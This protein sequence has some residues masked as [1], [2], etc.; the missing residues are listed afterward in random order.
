MSLS[1]S[2]TAAGKR[3]R[4]NA[5][6]HFISRALSKRT[7]IK[8]HFT[9][10][11]LS[12]RTFIKGHFISL[13]FYQPGILSAW[14]FI[15][16]AFYQPSILS[17]WH[18]ISLAFGKMTSLNGIYQHGIWSNKLH[19]IAFISMASS[20]DYSLNGTSPNDISTSVI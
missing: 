12:N 17:A 7:F 20:N 1:F 5:T 19:L 3:V 16:L 13:V 11:A 18:F 15:S 14:H 4:V 8:W 10:L 2:L 6:W 9:S